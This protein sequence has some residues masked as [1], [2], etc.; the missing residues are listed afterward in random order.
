MGSQAKPVHS[1]LSVLHVTITETETKTNMKK[2]AK[3][4]GRGWTY[5]IPNNHETLIV[6]VRKGS[7][8][9]E[10]KIISGS[11]DDDDDDD[12]D[13]GDS[14]NSSS[15]NSEPTIVPIHSTV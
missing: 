9:M 11:N 15:S 4:T 5:N 6:Y 1:D 14:S 13:D 2:S 3:T 10:T 7:C 12:D 8:T